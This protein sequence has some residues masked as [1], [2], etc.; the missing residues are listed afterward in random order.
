[1]TARAVA[2]ATAIVV[3]AAAAPALAH[4]SI[5]GVGPFVNGI[6]HPLSVPAHI[7][8]A[9]GLGLWIA[10]QD[11][12]RAVRLFVAAF[13]GALA[14]GLSAAGTVSISPLLALC[15]ALVAGLLAAAAWRAPAWGAAA[16]AAAA[17]V[18]IGLDSGADEIGARIGTWIGAQII[19]LGV[20]ALAV[21]LDAPWLRIGARVIGAWC[22]AIALL[23]LALA[24]RTEL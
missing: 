5:E 11:D 3:L 13:A 4:D 21:R 16:L 23:M 14:V 17:A 20:A 12:R 22:A 24:A 19:F 7:L 15:T 18:S 6:L 1:M 9:I 8:I 10:R 2:L